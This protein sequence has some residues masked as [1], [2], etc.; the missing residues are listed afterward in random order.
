MLMEKLVETY[1]NTEITG[2]IIPSGRMSEG[3]L[4]RFYRRYGFKTRVVPT[5]DGTI[6]I[7]IKRG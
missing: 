5:T 2:L 6:A 4:A 3:E 7:E 1:G